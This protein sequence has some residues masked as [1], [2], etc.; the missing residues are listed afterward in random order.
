M[1]RARGLVRKSP[2]RMNSPKHSMSIYTDILD[3]AKSLLE[4]SSTL[5]EEYAISLRQISCQILADL[6]RILGNTDTYPPTYCVVSSPEQ[7]STS[8]QSTLSSIAEENT[9]SSHVLE[10]KILPE[11]SLSI[12]PM[13]CHVRFNDANSTT[14]TDMSKTNKKNF[15]K[16]VK[17]LNLPNE[18]SLF[19][20]TIEFKLCTT[21]PK[22]FLSY[23]LPNGFVVKA[24]SPGGVIAA[25]EKAVHNRD[26]TANGWH[27]LK[28]RLNERELHSIGWTGWDSYT[29]NPK[30]ASFQMCTLLK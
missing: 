3:K 18:A 25:Y 5:G 22:P 26:V 8:F 30:T 13:K 6:I 17:F 21:G 4:I 14:S 15:Q 29:W 10:E 11:E 27:R 1:K 9:T 19:Y 23:T 7:T 2:T 16:F 24:E 12:T 28:M 20:G